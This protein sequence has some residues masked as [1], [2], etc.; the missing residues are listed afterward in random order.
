MTLGPAQ[1]GLVPL[2]RQETITPY[3]TNAF[4]LLFPIHQ[5]T[6]TPGPAQTGSTLPANLPQQ[7]FNTYINFYTQIPPIRVPNEILPATIVAQFVKICDKNSNYIGEAYDIFHDKIRYFL[8]T[9]YT[10]AIKQSQFHAVFLSILSGQ[11]KDY[12]V[13]N[14][15]QNITFAEM[16]GK[17]KIQFDT[18][19]NKAQYYTD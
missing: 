15:N 14:V 13:Y 9:C 4:G 17:M 7:L 1:I 16:Y 6:I 8:D 5:P 2:M 10:V 19:I 12:F 3:P 18:E 11:A